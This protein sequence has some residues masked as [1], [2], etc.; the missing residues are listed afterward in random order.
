MGSSMPGAPYAL[1][2]RIMSTRQIQWDGCQNVRDLGGLP[3]R[4]GES[5]RWRSIIR[6]D[7]PAK[8]TLNSVKLL[9]G[10]GVS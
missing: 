3:T 1:E 5:T 8:L 2:R 9:L 10:H 7:L 4:D 6:A